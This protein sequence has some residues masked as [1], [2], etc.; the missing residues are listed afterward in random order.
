M[1]IVI[2]LFLYG[3]SR[4][5]FIGSISLFLSYPFA[6]TLLAVIIV[7]AIFFSKR[8][9]FNFSLL[10]LSAT[11]SFFLADFIKIILHTARPFVE[12][13]IIPLYKEIGFSFPS[14]HSAIFSALA[15]CMFFINRKLGIL[16]GVF[17][18]L[19]G[20]SRIVIGVHYPIDVLGGF[21][22]G[23]IISYIFIRIFKKI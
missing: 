5:P 13:G 22:L 18:L 20:L 21:A 9:M 10:F 8:K 17:T 6:Y 15:F 1:N 4:N 16:V 3:L 11:F 23:F 2:F 12:L 7:W 14:E 19:I